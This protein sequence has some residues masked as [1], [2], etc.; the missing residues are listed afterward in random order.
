MLSY[1]WTNKLKINLNK[2]EVLFVRRISDTGNEFS[3]CSEWGCIA[4]EGSDLWSRMLLD[5]ELTLDAQVVTVARSIF[6]QLWLVCFLSQWVKFSYGYPCIGYIKT[7][8]CNVLSMGLPLN[9]PWKLQIEQNAATLVLISTRW[10]D[11]VTLQLHQKQW[12][13]VDFL[14]AIHVAF[15]VLNG[16]EWYLT[17]II[18]NMTPRCFLFI[19]AFFQLVSS[20]LATNK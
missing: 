3:S 11:W 6:P 1:I 5:P 14:N 7:G 16:W 2:T 12:L 19:L 13:P 18:T 8:F 10:F 4:Q 20:P 9:I 17:D 15:T